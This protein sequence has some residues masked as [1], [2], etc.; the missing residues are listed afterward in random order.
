M[1]KIFALFL[2]ILLPIASFAA[3]KTNTLNI[4]S[5][6]VE[7]FKNKNEIIFTKRVEASKPEFTIFADKMIVKYTENK[8]DKMDINSIK[9]ISNVKF[10]DEKN[11]VTGDEG[12]YDVPKGKIQLKNNIKAIQGG[13][14]LFAKEF[15]YFV[16]TGESN[17]IGNK[18]EDNRVTIIINNLEDLRKD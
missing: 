9:L 17:I 3:V 10:V 12:F 7:I 6:K 8:N 16:E 11:V 18:D 15:E 4:K 14:T 5:E 1:S 2:I 13:I